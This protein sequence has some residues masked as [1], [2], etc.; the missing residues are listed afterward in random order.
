[1]FKIIR[2]IASAFGFQNDQD[3]I[4]NP[5]ADAA[6]T[7]ASQVREFE[8]QRA[9]MTE[10]TRRYV[11]QLTDAA[12]SESGAPDQQKSSEVS[13]VN[14]R[15]S[16]ATNREA[17]R[18]I[19]LHVPQVNE[20]EAIQDMVHSIARRADLAQQG[21][22]REIAEREVRINRLNEAVAQLTVE[23]GRLKE[24]E[25]ALEADVQTRRDE[26]AARDVDISLLKTALETEQKGHRT[27]NETL[28][29][30][31]ENLETEKSNLR[32]ELEAKKWGSVLV[33][34]V[35]TIAVMVAVAWAY[36]HFH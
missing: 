10:K 14:D 34:V 17:A 33:S 19:H 2:N 23:N 21:F 15:E 11:Q 32:N 28:R 9:R 26:V 22:N 1:M 29:T 3:V 20:I 8:T 24:R 5:Q 31:L 30:T 25:R 18:V 12:A 7:L 27:T 6:L 4:E 13:V 35:V 36:A 16:P